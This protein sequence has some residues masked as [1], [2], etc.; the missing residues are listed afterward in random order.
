MFCTQYTQNF[1]S[2]EFYIPKFTQMNETI[3][4]NMPFISIEMLSQ[5]CKI[6]IFQLIITRIITGKLLCIFLFLWQQRHL[7]AK[8]EKYLLF[9]SCSVYPT[10]EWYSS[11]TEGCTSN[12]LPSHT[13]TPSHLSKCYNSVR[14]PLGQKKWLNIE[15]LKFNVS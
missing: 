4:Q 3:N 13:H 1:T 8:Q 12:F 10:K 2:S 5:N 11:T 7:V 14:Q 9:Y 15:A 6:K